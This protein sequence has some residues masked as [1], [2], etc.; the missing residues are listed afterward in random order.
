MAGGEAAM[1]L[2]NKGE[3][4][5][6]SN[7]SFLLIGGLFSSCSNVSVFDVLGQRSFG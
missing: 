1:M 2:V 4:L 3:S 6:T 7:A 5:A